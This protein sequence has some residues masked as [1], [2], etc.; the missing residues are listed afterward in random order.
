MRP[1]TV[2]LNWY[3]RS[4]EYGEPGLQDYARY[5]RMGLRFGCNLVLLARRAG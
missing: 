2:L 4:S 1:N 5:L 3:D